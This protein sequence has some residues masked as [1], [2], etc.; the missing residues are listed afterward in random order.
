MDDF[1]DYEKS[2]FGPIL[3]LDQPIAKVTK[4]PQLTQSFDKLIRA[5]ASKPASLLYSAAAGEW[6]TV[7]PIFLP[8]QMEKNQYKFYLLSSLWQTQVIQVLY[9]PSAPLP[10]P[11]PSLSVC[12]CVDWEL[13][14]AWSQAGLTHLLLSG[15]D[16]ETWVHVDALDWTWN[17]SSRF[18]APMASHRLYGRKRWLRIFERLMNTVEIGHTFWHNL[19]PRCRSSIV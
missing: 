1:Q 11:P 10:L 7:F 2:M 8:L 3:K 19:L 5:T 13:V 14:F 12:S 15:N 18:P 16:T 17:V 4:N 9:S 6:T